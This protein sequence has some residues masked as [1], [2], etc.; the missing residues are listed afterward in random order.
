MRILVTGAGGLIGSHLVQALAQTEHQVIALDR[1]I[2]PQRPGAEHVQV[3]DVT[4]MD[5][6]LPHCQGVD[7]IVHLPIR[8]IWTNPDLTEGLLGNLALDATVM[9]A[10]Q[11][12]GVPRFI[13]ASSVHA[14]NAT[15][16][17]RQVLDNVPA[18]LPLDGNMPY[19]P[20]NPYGLS[21]CVGEQALRLL[22]L[23]TGLPSVSFRLPYVLTEST[24]EHIRNG[25]MQVE[26]STSGFAWAALHVRD[27]VTLLHR[28][29]D[30]PLDGCRRYFPAGYMTALGLSAQDTIRRHLPHVPLRMPLEQIESIADLRP[31]RKDLQWEPT[32]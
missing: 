8:Y 25:T 23:N 29:I 19:C 6:L 9:E 17:Q 31:L 18:Y 21:K 7:V 13:Y 32:A 22:H 5:A 14:I 26:P 10:G 2:N 24:F 28:A 3:C 27:T 16:P 12:A 4:Q 30:C 20:G 11:R 15:S 1:R